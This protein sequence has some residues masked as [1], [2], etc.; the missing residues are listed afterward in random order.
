MTTEDIQTIGIYISAFGALAAAISAFYSARSSQITLSLYKKEKKEKL[1]DELNRILEIAVEY[2][3]LES[4][5]F[6]SKWLQYRETDAEKYLRYDMYCNLL[7]NYL[8]HVCE[9]YNYNKKEIESF[10]DVKTWIRLHKLNWQNPV[11]E[12]ENIDGYDE[13]YRAFINSYIK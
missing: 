13:N 2:P 3:Y 5:L 4:S 12:N 10:V 6:T 7:F 9:Y 8:H 11:D 1:H